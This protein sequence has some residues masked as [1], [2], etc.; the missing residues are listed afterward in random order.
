MQ[1]TWGLDGSSSDME[2]LAGGGGK[3]WG[4]SMG[5]DAELRMTMA[6]GIP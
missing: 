5:M 3:R 4:G 2:D 6:H 1:K